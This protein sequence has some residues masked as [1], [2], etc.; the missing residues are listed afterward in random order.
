LSGADYKLVEDREELDELAKRLAEVPEFAVD[1]EASDVDP[2]R[3]VLAGI[4]VAWE[5][6]RAWYVPVK[7]VLDEEPTMFAARAESPG[8]DLD[9]VRA[10]FGPVFRDPRVRKIGQNIKYDALV[11]GN[12][13]IELD[14]IAFDTMLA[15]YSLHPARKSHGLDSLAKEILGHDM[16]PFKSLFDT[17]AKKKDIRVVPLDRVAPYA[18]EDVDY[19]LRLKNVFEPLLGSSQVRALFEDVEMPLSLVLTRMERT[20]VA[21]DT[22]FLGRLSVELAD[23]LAG[24]EQSIY[25]E[26]GEQFN[27]NSTARLQHILFDKLGL[28]PSHKTKTGYSTDVDVLKNLAPQHPVPALVLEYRTNAKLKSTYID[29]LPRL[30]NS[31]TGRLHTSY[32]QAVTTTGRLS[33]SDPNLQNIPIRT[34]IGREI[35]KAF[36]SRGPDWVLLDADYSQIELRIMA[37]LSKDA[38]LVKAFVDDDDVHRRTAAR[39]M[40]VA[41]DEVSDEM[42]SRAKS[43]NFGIMYGMGARGLAQ[44][45]EIDVAE[46]KK[47]IDDYFEKYPGVR[48]FIEETIARA[49]EDQAVSTLLGRTRQLPDITGSD[50]RSQAFAERTAVNTPIQGTAADII[51]LAMVEI[52]RELSGGR[53]RAEMIMQ[54]HDELLFEVPRGELDDVKTLVREGMETAIA[55]DVPLKVDMGVGQNWL[56]AHI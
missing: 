54:V 49:R 46:A 42:R 33:S 15:S 23:K 47:F 4:S 30:V 5:E 39:I 36:V 43:V 28:K 51:K 26:A 7:S 40:G 27:I 17:R 18:C 31:E 3:A 19:T 20:G 1:V 2:M 12:A 24:I 52:D 48:R 45:L 35:R 9:V 29:A 14:G 44:S 34:E 8:F 13:G 6:N 56:E 50:R 10:A 11:L 25:D 32:N 55:L 41:P 16:I 38:E 21:L 37:H 53:Y 22:D